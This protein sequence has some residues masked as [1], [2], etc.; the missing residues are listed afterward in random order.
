MNWIS[1]YYFS[2][3]ILITF[4]SSC[5]TES[6]N[7]HWHIY[8]SN[9]KD[10]DYIV[11]NIVN[12]TLVTTDENSFYKKDSGYHNKNSKEINLPGECGSGLLK[13]QIIK[14]RIFL[15]GRILGGKYSGFRCD[16]TCCSP[17]E[18][19]FRYNQLNINLPII[20]IE[21][22][23]IA[24]NLNSELSFNVFIGKAKNNEIYG[25]TS[26]IEDKFGFNNFSDFEPDIKSFLSNFPEH[27]RNR[28]NYV[29]YADY[30]VESKL[31]LKVIEELKKNNV[32]RI[33][34]SYLKRNQNDDEKLIRFVSINKLN[35]G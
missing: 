28:I 33:F 25:D 1:K 12:D 3:I 29:I 31:L 30:E 5:K 13:Y 16:S 8:Q 10:N 22:D 7:G 9:S 4:L 26:R 2:T 11:I 15:E 14:D 21:M 24:K 20:S 27:K 34:L 23:S 18:E 35:L 19:Y 17:I 6:P 32:N